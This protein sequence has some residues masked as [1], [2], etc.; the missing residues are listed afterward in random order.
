MKK[1]YYAVAR[2][3]QQ[4]I[5]DE[6]KECT[7]MVKGYPGNVYRG[8]SSLGEAADYL[9]TVM[10]EYEGPYICRIGGE[11]RWFRYVYEMVECLRETNK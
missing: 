7:G 8:F 4:G 3:F 5:T 10:P 6:W 11:E 9:E 2:G 1:R